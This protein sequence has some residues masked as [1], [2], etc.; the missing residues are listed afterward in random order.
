MIK[1]NYFQGEADYLAWRP[2]AN[3][4]CDVTGLR[5][6]CLHPPLNELGKR[7]L[8]PN[9]TELELENKLKNRDFGGKDPYVYLYRRFNAEKLSCF[10]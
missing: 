6:I 7:F 4:V 1:V 8:I 3:Q 5:D 9:L 2:V 10:M